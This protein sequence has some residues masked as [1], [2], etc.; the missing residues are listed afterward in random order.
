MS[1]VSFADG[2]IPS[3]LQCHHLTFFLSRSSLLVWNFECCL[4][5]ILSVYRRNRW[6]IALTIFPDFLS[7]K[8]G[9]VEGHHSSR[10]IRIIGLPWIKMR[11]KQSCWL[12][13]SA[14]LN[15]VAYH[16]IVFG[17]SQVL[18]RDDSLSHPISF[19]HFAIDP[20][21]K[22]KVIHPSRIVSV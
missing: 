22:I 7:I 11:M 17:D 21:A 8:L 15:D 18:R 10:Y 19:E 5:V 3:A 2:Q 6:L 16:C 1:K 4:L 12:V 14:G 9:F 20:P 13:D